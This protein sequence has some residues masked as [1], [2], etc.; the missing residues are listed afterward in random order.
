MRSSC[1]RPRAATAGRQR[2]P[3]DFGDRVADPGD[4]R[5]SRRGAGPGLGAKD[6]ADPVGVGAEFA[7]ERLGDRLRLAAGDV[8]AAAG[9]VFGLA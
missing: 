5:G 1:L 7:F 6:D 9:Q 8:E 4:R 3:V 2:D